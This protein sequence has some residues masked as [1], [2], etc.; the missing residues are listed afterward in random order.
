MCVCSSAFIFLACKVWQFGGTATRVTTSDR[1]SH[2]ELLAKLAPGVHVD[3]DLC[4]TSSTFRLR[5]FVWKWSF[6][7]T[8]LTSYLHALH[9]NT[10]KCSKES[11]NSKKELVFIALVIGQNTNDHI[12]IIFNLVFCTENKLLLPSALT[13]HLNI[14]EVQKT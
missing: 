10:I 4:L 8:S 1:P 11:R 7:T 6:V 2:V 12:C 5:Q 9:S 13:H 14:A 3:V